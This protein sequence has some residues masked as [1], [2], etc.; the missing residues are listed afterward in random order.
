LSSVFFVFI[1]PILK[2]LRDKRLTHGD[3]HTGNVLVEDR[4][5]ILGSDPYAFRLTDFSCS[6]TTGDSDT[7]DDY[8]Q[9]ALIIRELLQNVDYQS[10]SARDRFVFDQINDVFL[11]KYLLESDLTR[12]PS[13]RNPAAIFDLVISFDSHWHKVEAA[14]GLSLSSPFDY[15]SC[16]QIG[17]A[18]HLLKS[19]YSERFLGLPSIEER[20]NIVLTGPRG[21]GKSTVYRSLSLRHRVLVGDDRP[22]DIR[23]IGIYY[24]C[25]DLYYAFPRYRL[26]GDDVFLNV[27]LHYVT[28]TLLA[29]LLETIES[30]AF[31]HFPDDFARLESDV[32]KAMWQILELPYSQIPGALTFK[33]LSD[34]LQK[35]RVRAV[36]KHKY[37]RTHANVGSYFGRDIV[38][39]AC[40]SLLNRLTFASNVPIY[41]FIDDYSSPKVT[42]DLQR[43]LNRL[44]M[45]RSS[46]CYFKLSTESPVSFERG[47]CDG[48]DYVEGREFRL[49]NVFSVF[50]HTSTER[51]QAFIEDIVNRRLALVSGYPVHDLT[52][53]IGETTLPSYNEIARN[54]RRREYPDLHGKQVLNDLC[55]GDLHYVIDLGVATLER[56]SLGRA[57][58]VVAGLFRCEKTS[59]GQSHRS[60]KWL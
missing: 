24:R 46:A 33:A 35:E 17:D 43:N 56:R 13:T 8:L 51:R 19:L 53:L 4:S 52:T 7:K 40:S 48:K 45:Q 3:L 18:H 27:P 32:S 23:Y 50:L 15:L 9:T 60:G 38:G 26:P 34:R 59:S 22:E 44:L 58:G 1:L 29:G 10:A 42:S 28:A 47:D 37:H 21:C 55:S 2:E 11:A 6:A 30:W 31:R 41:F 20:N 16:E 14:K 36:E 25:D 54:I 5:D 49:V 12:D 57:D 39:R